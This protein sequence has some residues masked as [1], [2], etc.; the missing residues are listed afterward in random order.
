VTP[1]LMSVR[2]RERSPSRCYWRWRKLAP[3][4]AGVLM[5]EG[6]DSLVLERQPRW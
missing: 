6:V 5:R 2:V 3:A 1:E 4:E